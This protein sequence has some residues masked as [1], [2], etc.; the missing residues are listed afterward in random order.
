[1]NPK[2]RSCLSVIG[3]GILGWAGLV[4]VLNMLVYMATEGGMSLRQMWEM[5]PITALLCFL[6]AVMMLA[7]YLRPRN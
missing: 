4:L 5:L 7:D 3:M 1:M 6:P 2:L